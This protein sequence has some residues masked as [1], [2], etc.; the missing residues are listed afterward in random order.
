ME[1]CP[2]FKLTKRL[3]MGG[4][5]D[6]WEG[7]STADGGKVAFKFL[8]CAN[9]SS[10]FVVNEIRLLVT[11]RDLHHPH[12]IQ[13]KNVLASPNYII[14]MM[15][16]ADWNLSDLH[17]AYREQAKAHVPPTL[18]CDLIDQS[19][20]ALDFLAQQKIQGLAF[21][22]TG[23]QH[24]D[25]KPSN[26]LML[27]NILKVAD[28][29]LSG[30]S[31]WN[32]RSTHFVGTPPYAAPEI[33]DGRVSERSD[34]FALAVTYYELRTGSYPF[35]L[36]EKL[37]APSSPPDLSRLPADKERLVLLKAMHRQW[38]DRYPSCRAF[39]SAL[40]EAVSAGDPAPL[41]TRE[42]AAALARR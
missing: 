41:P 25:V 1:P 39:A 9:Q 6:V 14:L 18:L 36:S 26:L 24:C 16:R 7:V 34:Q 3:G 12:V 42:G 15:E 23:L 8:N 37:K 31:L 27:N 10:T 40:R 21:G 20:D 2:G 22:G 17:R 33:Y 28:F 19:A 13:L 30:P 5:G 4:F 32:S 35:P 29:G 11:L 38:V